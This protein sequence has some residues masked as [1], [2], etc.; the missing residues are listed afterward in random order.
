M[1]PLIDRVR[2]DLQALRNLRLRDFALVQNPVEIFPEYTHVYL[3][4]R[5]Y[6]KLRKKSIE[7]SGKRL[8]FSKCDDIVLSQNETNER[9]HLHCQQL[10]IIL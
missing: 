5:L 7:I 6:L 2:L 9:A 8:T 10:N 4:K 1:R 3:P